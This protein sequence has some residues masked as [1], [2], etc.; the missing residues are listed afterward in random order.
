MTCFD[1]DCIIILI[2]I[3]LIFI[4]IL[5]KFRDNLNYGFARCNYY[6][7]LK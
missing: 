7:N 3:K 2:R 6:K 5:K 1:L 4:S